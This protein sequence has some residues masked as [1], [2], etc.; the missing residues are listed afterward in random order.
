[1]KEAVPSARNISVPLGITAAVSAIKTIANET[2][3]QNGVLLGMLLGGSQ[4]IR[5]HVVRQ[6]N[7][8]SWLWK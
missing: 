2:K 7:Y 8:K 1:M 6:R 5:K 4:F 3:E